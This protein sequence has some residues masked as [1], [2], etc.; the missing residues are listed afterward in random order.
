MK[1]NVSRCTKETLKLPE[2]IKQ[3]TDPPFVFIAARRLRL[4]IAILRIS[5]NSY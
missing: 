2:N 5:Q 3:K 1:Q 4:Y